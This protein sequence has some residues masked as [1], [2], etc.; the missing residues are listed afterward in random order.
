MNF[1]FVQ[2]VVVKSIILLTL[3][4]SSLLAQAFNL[5]FGL[6]FGTDKSHS[7]LII[8]PVVKNQ[9]C[10]LNNH[11]LFTY[12]P[13]TFDHKEKKFRDDVNSRLFKIKIDFRHIFESLRSKDGR[14]EFLLYGGYW[15]KGSIDINQTMKQN[16]FN[17]LKSDK[18]RDAR[19]I[20]ESLYSSVEFQ[21]FLN[22]TPTEIRI[23]TVILETE[24]GNVCGQF[25]DDKLI[26]MG[27]NKKGFPT[28]FDK[29]AR[30]IANKYKGSSS[31]YQ[32]NSYNAKERVCGSR[33]SNNCTI[34]VFESDVDT[35]TRLTMEY[36]D[37]SYKSGIFNKPLDAR[38]TGQRIPFIT[39]TDRIEL[40]KL[41]DNQWKVLDEYSHLVMRPMYLLL[42]KLIDLTNKR[43][44]NSSD[45]FLNQF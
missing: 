17:Y 21:N 26:Q 23:E 32:L 18:Y 10:N 8:K 15:S 11:G 6:E 25:L 19:F 43:N 29:I 41:Q 14:D 28:D 5:P 30:S 42:S 12:N 38:E 4:P 7:N 35:Q 44:N 36:F 22:F 45:S 20:I 9:Y 34:T 2:R 3:L 24:R 27:L 1:N 13:Y 39:Y 40:E 37:K 16:Y 31:T 33:N